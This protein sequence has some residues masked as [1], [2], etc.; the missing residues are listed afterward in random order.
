M[1]SSTIARRVAGTALAG[2]L[3]AA[4]VGLLAGTASAAAPADTVQLESVAAPQLTDVDRD[5]HDNDRDRDRNDH[6]DDHRGPAQFQQFQQF[7]PPTG[8]A[9]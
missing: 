3:L 5:H 2:A 9:L 7:L 8:S 1:L 6:R 4:P